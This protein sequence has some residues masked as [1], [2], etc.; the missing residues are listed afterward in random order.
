MNLKQLLD[1]LQAAYEGSTQGTWGKGMTTHHTVSD[2]CGYNRYPIAEFHHAADA[3][4]CDVAHEVAPLVV[5]RAEEL[6]EEQLGT[7][8]ALNMAL[9]G[10]D[11]TSTE[12]LVDAHEVDYNEEGLISLCRKLIAENVRLG[13]TVEFQ[14]AGWSADYDKLTRAEAVI[15]KVYKFI[16]SPIS[17]DSCLQMN[18]AIKEYQE[19]KKS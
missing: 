6:I 9:G 7:I 14:K 12:N 15:E 1:T 16:N 13:D 11:S 5:A 18:V 2:G 8:K 19:G 3:D 17:T 10:G 4:F